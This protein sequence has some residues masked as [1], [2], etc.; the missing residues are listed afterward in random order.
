MSNSP[1]GSGRPIGAANIMARE[2]QIP[3]DALEQIVHL[4]PAGRGL[5]SFRR[6]DLAPLDAGQ[7]RA[8]SLR[9]AL[10]AR[11]VAIVTGFCVVTPEGVTAETDG[12]PGALFLAR[13]LAALG[14]DVCLITDRYARPLLQCGIDLWRLE[15]VSL[16]EMPMCDDPAEAERWT[17]AFL[18]SPRGTGLSHLIAI[19]RPSPSHTT[20]SLAA[21]QDPSLPGDRFE[22]AV[23]EEHRG[24]CHNML[25]ELIQSFTADTH[26]LFDSISAQQLPIATIGIGDG[27]N[28]IGMGRFAWQTLVDAVGSPVAGRIAA[29]V[30]TDNAVIAGVSDWGAYALALSVA[31]LRGANDL[32]RDWDATGERALIESMVRDAGAVDGLTRRREPTVDGLPLDVYL[33][34]LDAMRKL[35]GYSPVS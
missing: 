35:L 3:W 9:L 12:P 6:D 18:A 26:R 30:A 10:D 31:C 4:D 19:E 24:V 32:G 11:S 33:Q 1:A 22:A 17:D 13:A 20:E 27:G 29:R 23:P 7:L 15:Q 25:G 16:V 8:A 2:A 14:I 28:E 21:Q 34:P 5:A